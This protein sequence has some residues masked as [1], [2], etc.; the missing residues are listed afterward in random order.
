MTAPKFMFNCFE[1]PDLDFVIFYYLFT[2]RHQLDRHKRILD[3]LN[4]V[5][6][7]TVSN[8][9]REAMVGDLNNPHMASSIDNFKE[10]EN[11]IFIVFMNN[12][13]PYDTKIQYYIKAC[14]DFFHVLY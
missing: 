7:L 4:N 2:K 1:L 10:F 3:V 12:E 14:N 8:D 11:E 5:Y 9:E 13:V 6:T